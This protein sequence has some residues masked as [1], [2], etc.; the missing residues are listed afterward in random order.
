ME[1]SNNYYH[2]LG[3]DVESTEQEIRLAYKQKLLNNHPDKSANYQIEIN[4]IQDAYRVLI[5]RETR[6]EYDVQLHKQT[7]TRGLL[8]NGDGLDI[9]N[10][11]SFDLRDDKFY[12]KCPRCSSKNGMVLTEQDLV[13]GSHDEQGNYEV[14]VQCT[15][16]SLWIRVQYAEDVSD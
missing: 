8:L 2:V 1:T 13:E 15:D 7:Q 10:L 12:K 9:Y 16:C 5:N 6:H 4:L 11:D 3:V 14:I